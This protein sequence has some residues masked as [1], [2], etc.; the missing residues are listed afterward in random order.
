MPLS[1]HDLQLW[2]VLLSVLKLPATICMKSQLQL[3]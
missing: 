3:D 2:Q 1:S